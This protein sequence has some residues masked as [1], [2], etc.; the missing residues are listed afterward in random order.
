MAE[1]AA[2]AGVSPSP[3]KRRAK[4]PAVA[5]THQQVQPTYSQLVRPTPL[6]S[7]PLFSQGDTASQA[8]PCPRPCS[9]STVSISEVLNYAGMT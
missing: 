5:A 1:A 2:G 8:G 3:G 4:E 9:S 7:P 6:S